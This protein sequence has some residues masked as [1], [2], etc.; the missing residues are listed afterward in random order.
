MSKLA[1]PFGLTGGIAC[2]KT[3][4]ANCFADLGAN[5]IDA[6]EIGHCLLRHADGDIYS[7][8]VQRFGTTILN[9]SGEI[10]RKRLGAIV[11]SNNER[12]RE[13]ESILHPRIITEHD[14]M[15]REYSRKDP[16][17]VVIVEA[18]LIYEAGTESHFRKIIVAWCSPEQQLQ[19][20]MAKTGISKAEAEAR[21][22]TQMPAE[23]KL[24]RADLVVDC[25]STLQN[26]RRQVHTLFRQLKQMVLE[27]APP[28]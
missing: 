12:R 11:F 1:L 4:V 7:K 20:L 15:A 21:I 24:R 17:A 25:S 13:L 2:G 27:E 8:V 22:S 14:Q 26:T 10:D 3:T 28:T 9:S 23:S 19:R 16:A 5:V 18:A 6:D